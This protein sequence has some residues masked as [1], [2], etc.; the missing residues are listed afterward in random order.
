MSGS[1]E[2]HARLA[3]RVSVWTRWATAG[4][5]V[6]ALALAGCSASSATP[7]AQPS[8]SP[9]AVGSIGIQPSE[10]VPVAVVSDGAPAS[11]SPTL[12]P[13]QVSFAQA[14][15]LTVERDTSTATRLLD[16]RVLIVGG[17]TEQPKGTVWNATAELFDPSTSTF[18]ATGSMSVARDGNTATLLKDGRVLVAGGTNGTIALASAEIYDPGTGTF[19]TTTS[20]SHA[21]TSAVAT[22][23]ADGRVLIAGGATGSPAS[24]SAEI[25]DPSGGKF[26]PTGS[27]SVGRSGP[28]A[29][30]LTDGRVLIVGGSGDT[31]LPLAS[32]EIYD[33][34]AGTFSAVGSLTYGRKFFT[35]TLLA[36]GKV[37]VAGGDDSQ[38]PAQSQALVLASAELFDPVTGEFTQT[39]SMTT[40]RRDHAA[41]LMADGRVLVTGGNNPNSGPGLRSAEIYS[42]ATGTFSPTSQSMAHARYRHTGTLLADGRVLIVGGFGDSQSGVSAEMC[43]P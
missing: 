32:A 14:G 39:G 6:A 30:R 16:G 17:Y 2:D 29:T 21:R 35:A 34:R 36:S 13:V 33:P 25:Y 22:L 5:A 12:T 11:G 20:M 26:T 27:M 9:A 37:L 23:L 8:A 3:R 10:S 42:P 41:T 1:A 28:A 7:A 31:G 19:I 4:L 15:N 24:A 43:V 40:E 38:G 18:A